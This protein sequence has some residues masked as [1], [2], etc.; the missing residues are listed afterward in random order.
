MSVAR[1]ALT[2]LPVALLF[3][4]PA[5]A[6]SAGLVPH[7]AVYDLDLADASD[8]SG[9][10]GITGRM[11]YE[12]DGSQCEGYTINFRFVTRINAGETERMTDQRST[13]YESGEGDSFSFLTTSYVDGNL[14]RELRGNAELDDDGL[15]V[16]ISEPKELTHELETT[17][18]PTH[19]ILDLIARAQDGERF[20]ETT[21][22]DGSE[23]ADKIL[24]TTAVIGN[25]ATLREDDAEAT[26]LGDF[27][28]DNY[29]PVDMAY[30][31]MTTT[32]GEELPVYRISF[33]LHEGGITR[34]LVMDYGDFSINGQLV[35]LEASEPRE[36]EDDE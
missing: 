15:T 3:A 2:I 11:V 14:D 32:E 20:Y 17:R 34:D 6:Q 25:Q 31:D 26:A 16:E 9:I 30:F 27:A 13:T 10:T 29:W 8:R 36:C 12:F 1:P 28:D 35:D 18:F 22:F 19:H 33:K 7:R 21:I 23:D 5:F 4:A 24:T